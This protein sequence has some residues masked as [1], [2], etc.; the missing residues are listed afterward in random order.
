MSPIITTV[1]PVHL[2]FFAG[3]EAIADAKAEIFS[4]VEPGGAAGAQHRQSA[5]RAAVGTR[6]KTRHETHRLVRRTQEGRG[7]A[8]RPA[9]HGDCSAVHADILKHDITYK[10]GMSGRHMAMNSLA[11]LAAS[12]LAGA[13]LARSP[14]SRLVTNAATGGRGVRRTLEVASGEAT[15]IDESYNANPAS[16]AAALNVLGQAPSARR[17]AHRDARRHAGTGPDRAGAA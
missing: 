4:G 10:L 16:M 15:L 14:R 6:R 3:I 13:D 11:V 9:L 2:E 1:E 17:P 12:C 8:D 7:A 5:I